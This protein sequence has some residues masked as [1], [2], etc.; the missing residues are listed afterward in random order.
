MLHAT[1][2]PAPKTGLTVLSSFFL[3]F[4]LKLSINI[5]Y[6]GDDFLFCQRSGNGFNG[7]FLFVFTLM[8]ATNLGLYF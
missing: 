5:L 6:W 7:C 3:V 4:L 1:P 8:L 2:S